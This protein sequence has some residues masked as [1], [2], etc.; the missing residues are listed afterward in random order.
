[1][2]RYEELP[3]LTLGVLTRSPPSAVRLALPA[4]R[5][6]FA[7]YACASR[8]SLEHFLVRSRKGRPFR[9]G[10]R[11]SRA[12]L[13]KRRRDA[14]NSLTRFR[15]QVLEGR[16]H[17]FVRHAASEISPAIRLL[18]NSTKLFLLGVGQLASA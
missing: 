5:C 1:M 11:R 3:S 2:P 15:R 4:A 6:S 7:G 13:A 8:R 18:L 16:Q 14:L 9:T 17:F 12:L 10:R